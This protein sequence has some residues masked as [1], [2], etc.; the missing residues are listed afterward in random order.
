[1]YITV[2]LIKEVFEN[3]YKKG[4]RNLRI[5][6]AYSSAA[7]LY[8]IVDRY[9][10]IHIELIIGMAGKDGILKADHEN[11]I[12]I[13]KTNPN[14]SVKYHKSLPAIHTKIY[15]WVDMDMF[16]DSVTYIGSANFSWNGF[17]DQIE[18]LAQSNYSNIE[19]VFNTI[20]VISCTDSNVGDYITFYED[21]SFKLNKK[22]KLEPIKKKISDE[23]PVRLPL[24]LEKDTAIHERS[25]LNWG[26]REGREPN[27]AYIPIPAKIHQKDPTF[28]PPTEHPFMLLTDDGTSFL[29]VISQANRKAIQTSLNNSLIGKYF[30]RRLNVPL[31]EKVEVQNVVNYG[32]TYVEIYKVDSETYF[33]DYSIDFDL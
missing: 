26:Q 28:F 2:N 1:M 10:G 24:L 30:R 20:D 32:K 17:R 21:V 11:F 23:L 14:I 15:Q 25:G 13:V 29:C 8:Y 33:M 22:N 4:Y 9:P 6:S 16:N 12:E 5:L 3:P 7:F 18:L 27:Q 19:E 31:G